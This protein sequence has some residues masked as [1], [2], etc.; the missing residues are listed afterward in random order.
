M[1]KLKNNLTDFLNSLYL[2]ARLLYF[3][4]TASQA[5]PGPA[6]SF[7]NKLKFIR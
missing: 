7:I 6:T 1:D 4:Q 5:K 2:L 3:T